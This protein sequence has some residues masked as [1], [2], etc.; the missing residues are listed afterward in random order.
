MSGFNFS[1]ESKKKLLNVVRTS[2]SYVASQT[3]RETDSYSSESD[4]SEHE[5]DELRMEKSNSG[6]K[7]KFNDLWQID[8][9]YAPWSQRVPATPDVLQALVTGISYIIHNRNAEIKE[10]AQRAVEALAQR[11]NAEL[12]PEIMLST[13]A[14]LLQI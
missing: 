7:I 11:A 4:S 2:K 13:N 5:E 10:I 8:K 1:E 6:K 14:L 3:P 9:V 12:I